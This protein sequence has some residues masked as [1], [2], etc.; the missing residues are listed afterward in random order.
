MKFR[1]ASFSVHFAELD[2]E[3]AV[4][5]EGDAGRRPGGHI[6]STLPVRTKRGVVASVA[7]VVTLM[8]YPD[9]IVHARDWSSFVKL[10]IVR[11]AG[12]VRMSES[13]ERGVTLLMGRLASGKVAECQ[14]VLFDTKYLSDLQAARWFA[15]HKPRFERVKERI[16]SEKQRRATSAG[17]RRQSITDLT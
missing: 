15:E 16:E 17:S 6:A 9:R 14:A 3:E 1:G 11:C 10:V 2:A 5:S 4:L 13:G 8:V 12:R 7:R